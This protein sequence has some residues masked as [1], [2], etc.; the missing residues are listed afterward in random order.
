MEDSFSSLIAGGTLG[1]DGEKVLV[2]S[3][4]ESAV[5]ADDCTLAGEVDFRAF[6]NTFRRVFRKAG[7]VTMSLSCCTTGRSSDG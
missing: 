7:G 2:S 3:S 6:A 1:P 5:A 4:L